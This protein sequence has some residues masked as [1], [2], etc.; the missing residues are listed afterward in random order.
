MLKV[1]LD[2][3]SQAFRSAL[4]V[5][6]EQ[7]NSR[8]SDLEKKIND[9]V[10]SL[11]FSQAEVADLQ[12]ELRTLQ[13]VDREQ[14]NKIEDLTTCVADMRL[15]VNYQE[16]YSRRNNLRI[17]GMQEL[18]NGETWEQT[19]EQVAKLFQQ[20]LQ[21]PPIALERAH[22]IGTSG[23]AQPRTVIAR[24]EKFQDREAVV[25]NAKKLKGTGIYVNEDLCPASQEIVR[26]QLPALKQARSEG[27]IAFFK[28][29]KLVIKERT[30][31]PS[32]TAPS[33][34]A[35][36]GSRTAASGGSQ[37]AASDGSRTAAS[38]G[39]QTAASAASAGVTG[40]THCAG[41]SRGAEASCDG[42]VPH[43]TAG[44]AGVGPAGA[45]AAT[46]GSPTAGQVA[47]GTPRAAG[48]SPDDVADAAR[49]GSGAGEGVCAA[50]ETHDGVHDGGVTA[51]DSATTSE[52]K[53][54]GTT[55]VRTKTDP[56]RRKKK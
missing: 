41:P 35:S 42:Y 11:E 40:H 4:D 5:L 54:A 21:L 30:G 13:K 1:L 18:A 6:A 29:T 26:N 38:G 33:G 9:L 7:F 34:A 49:A 48:G 23:R 43:G 55:Q 36:G 51:S 45:A 47:P 15:R 14:K 20:K 16:D 27:K 52:G 28:Y 44:P 39:S 56:K 46:G 25:R 10:N 50:D 32:A 53:E 24:F 22:R 17:S 8:I 37:T 3:N 31:H 2:S 12:G 19:A